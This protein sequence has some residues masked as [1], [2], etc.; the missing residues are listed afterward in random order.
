MSKESPQIQLAKE[1]GLLSQVPKIWSMTY[2]AF[3]ASLRNPATFAFGFI[4]PIVFISVFGLISSGDAISAKIGIPSGSVEQTPVLKALDAIAPIEISRGDEKELREK[5]TRGQ[6]DGLLTIQINQD[7]NQEADGTLYIVKLE[8]SNANPQTAGAVQALVSGVVDK[9]NLGLSGVKSPPVTYE[10]K[11]VSGREFRYIDYALPGQIGFALLSTAIFGTAFG[12]IFLKKT[13]VLKRIFATPTRPISI[14]LG[15]GGAR[16]ITALLQTLIIL[17]FGVVVFKF[18]L[19]NGWIT[20]A[21]MLVLSSL[22]LIVFLG[23]GLFISGISNDENAVAPIANLI[24]LPQFL[25]SG[26]F[27]STSLFPGWVEPIAK[28]L[29]LTFLNDAIR[30]VATE[31][32]SFVDIRTQILALLVWG[33]I[34]YFLAA[35]TFKWQ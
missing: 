34:A 33:V 24:T 9:L 12:L 5:L 35:R 1:P 19:A 32:A 2:Y 7:R 23:F 16:L 22:G 8:S 4:F 13:L 26:T 29:P 31:G 21:Q 18:H 27:F 28:I 17:V 14:I 6:I 10:S 30:K 3:K 20:F 15:Q 11:Q 25:L